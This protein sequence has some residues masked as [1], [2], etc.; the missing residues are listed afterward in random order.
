MRAAAILSAL[1]LAA[2][3][4]AADWG[5]FGYDAARSSASPVSTGITAGNLSKLHRRQVQL[6]GTV[7]SS[8]IYLHDVTV[9]GKRHDVLVMP[10][11]YGR[12]EAI[13]PASGTV[14]WRYVPASYGSL[15]RS[16]QITTATPIADPDRRFV[17]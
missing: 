8:A 16:A 10:T 5:R 2:G 6:D 14:L 3:P 13:D 11:T 12:T 15:A 17:Y 1:A 9:G 7:D 4:G